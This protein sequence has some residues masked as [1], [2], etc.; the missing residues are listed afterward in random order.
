MIAGVSAVLIASSSL[1]NAAK[2]AFPTVLLI[3]GYWSVLHIR[4]YYHVGR[5]LRTLETGINSIRR[6]P[7]LTWENRD[8]IRGQRITGSGIAV[9]SALSAVWLSLILLWAL[10]QGWAAVPQIAVWGFL[11]SKGVA[12]GHIAAGVY[13][14]VIGAAGI[15]CLTM[16]TLTM[17]PEVRTRVKRTRQAGEPLEKK[18]VSSDRGLGGRP[19][20]TSK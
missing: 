9:I 12:V 4:S 20:G 14:V 6:D 2:V 7:L 16:G 5:H 18:A 3:F 19:T 13:A 15:W 1:P 10:K 8:S 17:A 11:G